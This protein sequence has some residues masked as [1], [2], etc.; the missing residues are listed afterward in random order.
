MIPSSRNAELTSSRIDTLRIV[1]AGALVIALTM[2]LVMPL[3]PLLAQRASA[4]GGREGRERAE[5]VSALGA[6]DQW[7]VQRYRGVQLLPD[8]ARAPW[9]VAASSPLARVETMRAGG[10]MDTLYAVHVGV[11]EDMPPLR[12]RSRARLTGPTGS[13]SPLEVRVIAR[14]P[15]QTLGR[16]AGVQAP[17]SAWRHGWA[18]VA[19]VPR[20]SPRTANSRYHGW[21]LLAS[22]DSI[23]DRASR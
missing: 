21:L 19:L 20:T 5:R 10:Q 13:I 22:P 15:F 9:S 11:R 3:A 8:S 23:P 14:R 12:T 17:I 2:A 4:P 18:Y 7:L 6:L 16:P 1:V